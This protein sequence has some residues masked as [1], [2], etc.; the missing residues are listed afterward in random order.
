MKLTKR[1]LTESSKMLTK[2]EEDKKNLD[3]SNQALEEER[4][5]IQVQIQ[6]AKNKISESTDNRPLRREKVNVF[7]SEK[8]SEA[9][10]LMK[11]SNQEAEM[12]S[13]QKNLVPGRAKV[14]QE[15]RTLAE[16]K[17]KTKNQSEHID[18]LQ[19][20]AKKLNSELVECDGKVE[21][22]SM[23]AKQLSRMC[24]DLEITCFDQ[25]DEE[26][27]MILEVRR[28]ESNLFRAKQENQGKLKEF[29]L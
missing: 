14:E 28:V 24:R 20:D 29:I 21:E 17:E 26:H 8:C 16:L 22:A 25:E 19:D 6:R 4:K 27:R 11:A 15:G 2:L 7:I 5:A 18:Q 13:L 1:R 3:V 23:E 10:L 9:E 12:E